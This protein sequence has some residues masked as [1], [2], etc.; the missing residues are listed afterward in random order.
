ML[1]DIESGFIGLKALAEYLAISLR[2]VHRMV[3]AGQIPT[4]KIGRRRVVSRDA[5][6]DWLAS[7]TERQIENGA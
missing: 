5:I 2:G 7:R 4:V 3:A 6:K 1:R